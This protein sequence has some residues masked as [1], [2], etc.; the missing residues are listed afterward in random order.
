MHRDRTQ[1]ALIC[2]PVV[3]AVAAIITAIVL[4][5]SG[6]RRPMTS[7]ADCG[8][9]EVGMTRAQVEHVLGGPPGDYCTR[10]ALPPE[11]GWKYAHWDQWYGDGGMVF[12]RFDEDGRLSDKRHFDHWVPRQPSLIDRILSKR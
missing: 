6:P 5:I 7:Q 12:A 9:I 11:T 8:R 10:P 4:Y 3:L 2:V 1:L